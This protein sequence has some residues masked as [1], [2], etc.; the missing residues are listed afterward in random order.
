MIPILPLLAPVVGGI[1]NGVLGGNATENA[2]RE[3][4]DWAREQ[5]QIQNEYN[6]SMW[7]R[8]TEYNNPQNTMK[9]Y[10]DAGLNPNMIAGQATGN[11]AQAPQGSAP[12]NYVAQ[13]KQI[14][15]AM[16]ILGQFNNLRLGEAQTD[17]LKVNNTVQQ[18]EAALKAAQTQGILIENSKKAGI[19]DGNLEAIKADIKSK[20]DRNR[21]EEEKLPFETNLM[22]SQNNKTIT[23]ENTSMW[24]GVIN[25]QL[26]KKAISDTEATQLENQMRRYEI[27]LRKQGL[28]ERDPAWARMII[29]QLNKYGLMK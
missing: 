1:I 6:T 9:R 4:R 28:N 25:K 17:N 10:V 22:N 5:Q 26:G 18:E 8:Q 19:L 29:Q 3:N 15:D 11:M 12:A 21:R 7:E 27:Q 13:P 16:G 14:P 2:N 20:L 24:Q 23:D